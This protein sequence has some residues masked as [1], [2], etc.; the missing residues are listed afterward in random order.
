MMRTF[1]FLLLLVMIGY[2]QTAPN[3]VF[4]PKLENK[5]MSVYSSSGEII[6]QKYFN[7][8]EELLVNLSDASETEYLIR[9]KKIEGGIPKYSVFIYCVTDSFFLIDSVYSGVYEPAP[10]F[11]NE[12]E[13]TMLL[14]GIPDFD[15]LYSPF[16][17]E[18]FSAVNCLLFDDGKL[19]NANDLVYEIFLQENEQIVA[20]IESSWNGYTKDCSAT[21]EIRSAIAAVYVN[22][23]NAG[24]KVL[25]RQFLND[26]YLCPDKETFIN[27]L[28]SQ[29]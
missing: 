19:Y 24:E 25:A 16:E 15:S 3:K 13:R 26:Y 21:K 10:Y 17:H 14:T 9:D 20:S 2:G 4:E 18:Y 1:G 6:F 5:K 11:S 29:F 27:F 7:D 23:H 8:P 12:L 28:D 22:Y